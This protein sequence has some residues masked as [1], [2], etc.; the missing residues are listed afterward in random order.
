MN[1]VGLKSLYFV[2]SMPRLY[3][4]SIKC[5]AYLENQLF[6]SDTDCQT[7]LVTIVSNPNP[8]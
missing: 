1:S 8:V 7:P 3:Q 5:A 4:I 2:P 6:A